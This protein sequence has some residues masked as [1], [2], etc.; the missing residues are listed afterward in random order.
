M[1]D[2]MVQL[3][4]LVETTHAGRLVHRSDRFAGMISRLGRLGRL[5]CHAPGRVA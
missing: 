1:I 2:D 3:E 4:R 5:A